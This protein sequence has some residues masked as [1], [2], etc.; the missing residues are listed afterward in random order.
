[1]NHDDFF[2]TYGFSMEELQQMVESRQFRRLK[3]CLTELNEADAADFLESLP[4]EDRLM[5]FRLLNKDQASDI[6]AFLPIEVQKHIIDSI[7]DTELGRI[8][9]DLYVDDAVDMLEELPASVVQR[10]LKNAKP[11]TRKL[12]N[13]FLKYPEN[14]AGSIMTAEYLALKKEMTV[15]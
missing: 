3:E 11:D 15:Y 9:E 4:P 6:F 1:M 2:E 8:V 14:S 5:A 12:I 13:Q 10:V 7:T